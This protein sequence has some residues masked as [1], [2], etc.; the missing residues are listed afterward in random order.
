MEINPQTWLHIE[1]YDF[2]HE[3]DERE[4][5][6]F[7]VDGD[8]YTRPLWLACLHL[9]PAVGPG[10]AFRQKLIKDMLAFETSE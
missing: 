4:A 3:P 8:N 7:G 10:P 2:T 6:R 1:F 5:R 9:L